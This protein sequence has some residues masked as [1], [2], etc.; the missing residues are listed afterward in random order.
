MAETI[1]PVVYGGRA[2]WA[3]ALSLH[4]AA[5]TIAAAVFGAALAS[6]GLVLGAPWGRAGWLGVAA[7]ALL[8]AVGESSHASVTVPQLRRQVPDWWRTYFNPWTTAILYGGGLGVGFF[9]FVAHGTLAAVAVAAAASGHPLAGALMLAPFG[10]ARGLSPLVASAVRTDEDGQR[11]VDRL[12][13]TPSEHRRRANGAAL[14][15][16]AAVFV[17]ASTR[18]SGGWASFAVAVF[19]FTFAWASVSKLVT[20]RRWTKTVSAH[21]LPG[22]VPAV[23]AV[24]VPVA[25]AAVVVLGL[26]G[27]QRASA[28]W[29]LALLVAFTIETVRVGSHGRAPC[30]CFGGRGEADVS[31]VLARNAAL[32]AA[33]VVV[34]LAPSGAPTIH[35]PGLPDASEMVP[36]ALATGAVV[37]AAVTMWRSSAW[38]GTG[39][40]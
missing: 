5:A 13:A 6:A 4:A 19:A 22:P 30:G 26:A 40:R 36:A 32:G 3:V 20:W 27:L 17:V 8:Y 29:A 16:M 31:M 10:L 23:V 15:T 24:S 11:L 14:L 35:W 7:V 39:R 38:L 9:T 33:A 34:L 37:V 28:V 12:A 2:R 21:R 1:T 25:E 18:A